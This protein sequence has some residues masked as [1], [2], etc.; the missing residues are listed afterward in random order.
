MKFQIMLALLNIICMHR[1]IHASEVAQKRLKCITGSIAAS[2]I[3]KT[4]GAKKFEVYEKTQ[5]QLQQLDPKFDIC[6]RAK[7]EE[8]IVLNSKNMETRDL[9][10]VTAA[11]QSKDENIALLYARNLKS[12][13]KVLIFHEPTLRPDFPHI[14]LK[15]GFSF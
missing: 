6:Y 7:T 8:F 4:Y 14:W 10:E 15:G 2:L 12:G 11:S 5:Q 9:I 3:R 13:E 1:A